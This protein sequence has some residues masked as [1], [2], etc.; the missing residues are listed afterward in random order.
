MR[1]GECE[2]EKEIPR[3]LSERLELQD[4]KGLQFL[5]LSLLCVTIIQTEK[6]L[7]QSQPEKSKL[8]SLSKKNAPGFFKVYCFETHIQIITERLR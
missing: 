7:L 6:M 2:K 1:E 5:H 3:K 8:L 4:C